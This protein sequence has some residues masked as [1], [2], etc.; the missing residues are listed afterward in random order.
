MRHF[1]AYL[2]EQGLGEPLFFIRV[3]KSI[4]ESADATRYSV[5]VNYR[6]TVDEILEASAKIILG[7]ISAGLKGHGYHTKH[8]Y[9][10]SP[11]RLV[12]SSRAFDDGEWVVL[13]SWNKQQKCYIISKGFYNKDRRT[14]SVQSSEKCSS[15]NA[16]EITKQV[17]NLIHHLKDKP[18]RHLEKLKGVNLKR[19]PKS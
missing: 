4:L 3:L 10:E 16:A 8:V 18:D 19:G 17:Y 5:E 2:V 11:L 14:V 9:T 1:S 6:S 7:Y 15:D 13:V 12:V